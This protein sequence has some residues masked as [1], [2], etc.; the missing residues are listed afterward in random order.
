MK[1]VK[2]TLGLMLAILFVGANFSNAVVYEPENP[3]KQYLHQKGTAVLGN[4][5]IPVGVSID[6]SAFYANNTSIAAFSG[7]NTAIEV[8]ISRILDGVYLD[9]LKI[10]GL[11][12]VNSSGKDLDLRLEGGYLD[13]T[14]SSV[15]ISTRYQFSAIDTYLEN[16]V[17]L[18]EY[19]KIK[20]TYTD[21]N[22]TMT[23]LKRT[24]VLGMMVYDPELEKNVW[25]PS[26]GVA[27]I[28]DLLTPVAVFDKTQFTDGTGIATFTYRQNLTALYK[29]YPIYAMY[30]EI[31]TNDETNTPYVH[32]YGEG[33]AYPQTNR[34]LTINTANGITTSHKEWELVKSGYDYTFDVYA[35]AGKDLEITT[36]SEFWTADN[37]GIKVV[38][39][40]S[41]KWTVTLKK[42]RVTMTVNIGFANSLESAGGGEGQTGNGFFKEDK[43]WGSGRTLYVKSAGAGTL[44]IYSVTGQLI[45]STIVN[46]DYTTTLPKGLYI[47]KLKNK[48][49]KAI[50]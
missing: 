45:N 31:W 28:E 42:L 22:E 11:K 36:N 17:T 4:Y 26:T 32:N 48:A 33:N 40:G 3:A 29:K 35:E 41:G 43:V 23:F 25:V 47:I 38:P 44:S 15:G 37:G 39:K 21:G 10:D 46:G 14:T 16:N 7:T 13:G 2:F 12:G 20:L 49:Y 1:K 19:A 50:L 6:P 5:V 9:T 30:Y 34:K 27:P 24:I 18:E 8:G